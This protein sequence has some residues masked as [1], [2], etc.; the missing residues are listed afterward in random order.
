VEEFTASSTE[1]AVVA[2]VVVNASLGEHGVVL[3]LGLLEGRAVVGDED[4]LG[5]AGAERAEG[6]LGSEDVA[7]TADHQLKLG[8][9]VLN[10]G[11]DLRHD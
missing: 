8:V 1:G 3:N 7:T 10:S 2:T 5:S 4:H 9:D 11:L 6:L